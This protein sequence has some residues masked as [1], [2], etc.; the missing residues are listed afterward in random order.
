MAFWRI[1]RDPASSTGD[2]PSSSAR[3]ASARPLLAAATGDRQARR[4]TSWPCSPPS[5]ALRLRQGREPPR[6][7]DPE[8]HDPEAHA[9]ENRRPG[10]TEP[11][12]HGFC[13]RAARLIFLA[14][15]VRHPPPARQAPA[16]CTPDQA[17]NLGSGSSY[18]LVPQLPGAGAWRS[19]CSSGCSPSRRRH[20]GP[21]R[22]ARGASTPAASD[23]GGH[24][25]GLPDWGTAAP[26]GRGA[27]AGEPAVG[28]HRAGP[29]RLRL[30]VHSAAL[31][32]D[33]GLCLL[34]NGHRTRRRHRRN[35]YASIVFFI[36]YGLWRHRLGCGSNR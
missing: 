22:G 23:D 31:L 35:L 12:L 1:H 4:G 7:G 25:S 14:G 13:I 10:M 16:G 5:R 3:A 8:A 11:T 15:S 34:L 32:F 30:H 29:A 18:R 20:R 17:D 27:P 36:T 6:R 28:G 33:L 26:A 9:P 19:W 2:G 24:L 21:A